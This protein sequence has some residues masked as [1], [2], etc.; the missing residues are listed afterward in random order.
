MTHR[1][2]DFAIQYRLLTTSFFSIVRKALSD[3]M[4]QIY[5]SENFFSKNTF[6]EYTMLYIK[7][8]FSKIILIILTK[9]FKT[10]KILKMENKH[11]EHY[12]SA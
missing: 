7:N 6:R 5:L 9:I 2:F 8:T 10:Q 1:F 12:Q 11:P 3:R 4:N